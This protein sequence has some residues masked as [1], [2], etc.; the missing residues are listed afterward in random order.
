MTLRVVRALPV[1]PAGHVE[2][3]LDDDGRALGQRRRRSRRSCRSS[4]RPAR[5]C[6]CAPCRRRLCRGSS[7]RRGTRWPRRSRWRGSAARAGRPRRPARRTCA[8]DLGRRRSAM[9]IGGPPVSA[10]VAGRFG[11][12]QKPVPASMRS[13]SPSSELWVLPRPTQLMLAG[14]HAVLGGHAASWTSGPIGFRAAQRAVVGLDVS[15]V[16][17]SPPAVRP[18]VTSLGV[19]VPRSEILV[20]AGRRNGIHAR[21]TRHRLPTSAQFTAFTVAGR[22][23]VH[24]RP[25]AGTRPATS[26]FRRGH[27]ENI[28]VVPC[29]TE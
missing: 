28:G 26:G 5:G 14:P 2:V 12:C 23:G 7:P 20:A 4:R 19:A 13:R 25:T 22:S 21:H 24:R 16:M 29:R 9:D 17:S 1:L 8:E 6:P 18:A 10:W 11:A 3:A 15:S 27:P